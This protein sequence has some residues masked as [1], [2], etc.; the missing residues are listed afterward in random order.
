MIGVGGPYAN[1]FAYYFNDFTDAFFG[2]WEFTPYGP[3]QGKIIAASCWNVSS[4]HIAHGGNAYASDGTVGYATI[5]TYKDIN[6]TIGFLVWGYDARDTFHASKFFDEE[7]I[8]ELQRFP[9]CATSIIL[10]IDYY[11]SLHPTFTIVE[12]LGTI[13]ETMVYDSLY[14]DPCTSPY[15]GGIHDP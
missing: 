3:Y 15:K 5:T 4:N 11:D 1:L 9:L 6:G 7:L 14:R 12:V 2:L 8:Y 10:E 13:S